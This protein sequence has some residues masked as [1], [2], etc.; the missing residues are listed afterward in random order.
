MRGN[1]VAVAVGLTI[2]L[3]LVMVFQSAKGECPPCKNNEPPL[4][5]HGAAP[6]GSGRRILTVQIQTGTGSGSWSDQPDGGTNPNIWNGLNGCTGCAQPGA[7]Q[8]W[9]ANGTYYYFQTDQS[10]PNPDII[11]VKDGVSPGACASS[12]WQGQPGT[13]P[14]KMH[15]TSATAGYSPAT[16]ASRIAHE[17]GHQIGLADVASSVCISIMN[18]ASASG[19]ATNA[20][21]TIKARDVASSNQNANDSTRASC[22]S[23]NPYFPQPQNPPPPEDCSQIDCATW[24]AP[25]GY[26]GTCCMSPILVDVAGDGF[27]LT[28]AAGGV[29]FDL[30]ADGAAELLSWTAANSDDAF[31]VLDRTGNGTIDNGTELFGNFTHQPTSSSRNGFI[32]LAEYDKPLNGGNDDGRIDTH[33]AIFSSLRLWQDANHNGISEPNELH[34]LPELGVY[35]I[36]LDYRESRRTDQYGNQFRYRAKVYDTHGASVGRWAWDVFFVGGQ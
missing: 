22:T 1:H 16:I 20:T 11:I 4:P 19:C 13:P 31:L 17:V 29:N 36:S 32:A 35:A 9:N 6:D 28:D 7:N 24:I 27:D 15:L 30:N 14:L 12:D 3:P 18:A 26:N 25:E 21:T 23:T 34:T 33:D 10:T 2:I 8:M 5:G